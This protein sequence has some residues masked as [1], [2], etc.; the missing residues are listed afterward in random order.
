M[1]GSNRSGDLKDAQR[2]IPLGTVCATLATSLLYIL[3]TLLFGAVSERG[4]LSAKNEILF[5]AVVSWPSEYVVRVGIVLSSF[6]AGLQSLTGAPRLLQAIANDNLIPALH[7]FRGA[8]E[9]RRAL[10]CT[11][12]ICFGCVMVGNLD[13]LSPLITM[14]FLL[15]YTAV[16]ASVL[17]Q[18][19]LRPPN[20]RPRFRYYHP[21]TAMLGLCLCLFIMFASEFNRFCAIPIGVILLICAL[22]KYIEH[23]KVAA[24]WGDSMRGLRYQRARNALLELEKLGEVRHTKNWRPQVLPFCNA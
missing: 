16:N 14:F 12:C 18:E 13:P 17:I 1:A 10:L 4:I 8:G 6:G 24:Q 2:S 23:R 7:W 19:W 15:C 5:T 3:S 9:P 20:W 11:F 21:A 22:Y